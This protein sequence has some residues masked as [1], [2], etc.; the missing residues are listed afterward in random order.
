MPTINIVVYCIFHDKTFLI[1]SKARKNFKS[2]F[3][4]VT[5]NMQT[6]YPILSTFVLLVSMVLITPPLVEATPLSALT[7]GAHIKGKL[8]SYFQPR[9]L[10]TVPDQT[11]Y[12]MGTDLKVETGSWNGL[13]LGSAWFGSTD[14]GLI[15][16]DLQASNPIL[17]VSEIS[18]FAEAYLKYNNF[19]TEITAGRQRIETPFMNGADSLLF[20]VTFL[21]YSISNKSIKNVELYAAHVSDVKIRQNDFFEDTDQFISRQ[22][23]LSSLRTPGTTVVGARWKKDSFKLEG[24]NY[25]FHDLYDLFYL[26]SDMDL[27]KIVEYQAKLGFQ[28]GHQIDIGESKLG[29]VSASL[30]GANLRIQRKSVTASY[31]SNY[32]PSKADRFRNGGFLSPYSFA[33]DAIYTNKL[34]GGLTV[35]GSAFVGWAHSWGINYVCKDSLSLG[36]N[37]TL[38]DLP[39]SLGGQDSRETNINF[40]YKFKGALKGLSVMNRIGIIQSNLASENLIEDRFM[41]QY[42]FD[43]FL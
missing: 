43:L 16:E 19:D 37:F 27:P 29:N 2:M 3:T 42:D 6:R 28:A 4:K 8:R 22:L 38:F 10:D 32:I 34:D 31:A 7:E 20:P 11:L 24:W 25:I 30:F 21:G 26:E 12:Q 23:G 14:F 36:V 17:P 18:I 5:I 35:K 15:R 40:R 9:K 33:T 1:L 39:E 41:V 13:K